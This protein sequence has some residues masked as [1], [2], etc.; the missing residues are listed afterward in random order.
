MIRHR[1]ELVE[2]NA[3]ALADDRSHAHGDLAVSHLGNADHIDICD[4]LRDFLGA[5]SL[6]LHANCINRELVAAEAHN[7]IA[8]GEAAPQAVRDLNER[9]VSDCMPEAV[10]DGFELVH[11]EQAEHSLYAAVY[12]LF[13]AAL[14]A[15]AVADGG[16]RVCFGQHYQTVF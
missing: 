10:V 15:S 2:L 13:S 3:R 12:Q 11:I 7:H 6:S 4:E 5:L 8:A 9:L 1:I 14:S 16:Q